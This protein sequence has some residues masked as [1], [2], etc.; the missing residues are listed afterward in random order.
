LPAKNFL[1]KI[2]KEDLSKMTT[3][4]LQKQIKTTKFITGL[5]I[6]ILIVTVLAKLTSAILSKEFSIGDLVTP[7]ALMPIAIVMFGRIKTLKEE[8]ARR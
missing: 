7:F 5:F 4:E 1:P 8:L 2:M 3:E 6:G